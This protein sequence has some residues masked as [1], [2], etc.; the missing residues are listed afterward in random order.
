MSDKPG[1]SSDTE[2][3]KEDDK[4]KDKKKTKLPPLTPSISGSETASPEINRNLDELRNREDLT[5]WL[6]DIEEERKSEVER[7]QK[8]RRTI[9]PSLYNRRRITRPGTDIKK[10]LEE[11]ALEMKRGGWQEE[12]SP[13]KLDSEKKPEHGRIMKRIIPTVDDPTTPTID[14]SPSPTFTPRYGLLF[15]STDASPEISIRMNNNTPMTI[16]NALI[17]SITLFCFSLIILAVSIYK[18]KYS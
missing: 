3:T 18:L 15:D 12:P 6:D 17:I 2:K 13:L 4:K 11:L 1:G 7:R 10:E 14:L 16:R 8:E 5:A 9:R